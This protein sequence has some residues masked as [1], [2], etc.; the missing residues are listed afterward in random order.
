MRM[1]NSQGMTAADVVNTYDEPEL[2]KI[3]KEYGEERFARQ[4]A[5]AIV[6]ERKSEAFS[7]STQLAGL[8]VKVVPFIPGKSSGHPA[9]RVFQA[10]RIEVNG[11]LDALSSAVPQALD[12]L[13]VG[14][15]ILVLSYQSLEDRIVKRALG[16]ASV[17][18]APLDMPIELPEHAP[19]LRLVVRGA[20]QASDQEISANPRSASVRLRAAEKIRQAA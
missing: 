16:A 3:F 18:S 1:D 9:K 7:T 4:I 8:I 10:L 6:A 2:I 20:E 14:G 15:R 5:R 19:T 17:S 13:R 11:E 12:A